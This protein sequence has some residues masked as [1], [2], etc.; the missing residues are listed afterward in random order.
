MKI[1]LNVKMITELYIDKG[2]SLLDISKI[3]N[4]S[5]AT[6]T[7]RLREQGVFIRNN[8]I[9]PPSEHSIICDYYKKHT[10]KSC[11][12]IALNY[13]VNKTTIANIL[14]RNGIKP[15]FGGR[16][17]LIDEKKLQDLYL[18][19]LYSIQ[20][21]A[22]KLG[23]SNT[24][25]RNCLKKLKI[26]FRSIS[27]SLTDNTITNE[28]IIDLYW[29]QR[30]S[31]AEIA[32]KLGK[33]DVFVRSRLK[34][35]GK[36]TRSISQ[37]ARLRWKSDEISNEQLIYL[38]DILG[39]SCAKISR[40]YNKQEEFVTRRFRAIGKS[41]RK[42][43]GKYHY[44]WKGGVGGITTEIRNC[45]QS[46][47]W[48]K[49]A[50]IREQYKSEISGEGG[51][52]NCHH[53]YPFRLILQTSST[54]HKPLSDIYHDLAIIHDQR[55]YD[56]T[57]SLVLTK[58]EHNKIEQIKANA[59][60]WWK[61]WRAYPD[62]A[63]KRSNLNSVDFQLFNDKGQLQPVEY[64]LQTSTAKEI[65]QIIRYE[66]YLGTLPGSKLILVAKRG[67]I[68]I[69]IATFGTGTN[70]HIAQDT[71]ELTR[72]CIPFYVVRPFACEFLDKCCTYIRN[73]HPQIKQLI[74]FA[75]SSV[76]HNG[77]VYRM[78]GWQKAGKTQPSYAYFDPGIFKLRHKAACRRIKG[79]NK[80]ERELA[81]ER[82]WI[83]IPL[84]YKYRYTLNL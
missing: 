58:K 18:N 31:S 64:T 29:D 52:L 76:G 11:V 24:A 3:V 69:G 2:W 20:E 53:L 83:R 17:A 36:G 22:V 66:H 80:T 75:D 38:H 63:I 10:G 21:C 13:G 7:K 79:V 71:W 12:D 67:G 70:K 28:Q 82:G 8:R 5:V 73:H 60:P 33:S 26:K 46:R 4:C 6:V 56:G 59:H 41:R 42:N 37:G 74:A 84:G 35:S 19:Q 9:I 34:K 48:R 50:F 72:L 68:I 61:I 78:A 23:F 14:K 57:N 40:Y 27:E 81:Q 49:N 25:I 65:R 45:Q 54:K 44:N 30:L 47:D 43:I 32:Q 62:F 16:F 1:S 51:K 39:W 55:F 77:G 15:K